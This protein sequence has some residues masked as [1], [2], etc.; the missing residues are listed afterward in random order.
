MNA[1]NNNNNNNNFDNHY[2]D[3]QKQNHYLST[4][5]QFS[6]VG[7]TMLITTAVSNQNVRLESKPDLLIAVTPPHPRL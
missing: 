1:N 4:H 6:L 5:A 3:K 2:D 7:I